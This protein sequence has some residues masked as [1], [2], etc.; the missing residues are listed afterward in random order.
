ML[1]ALLAVL[2][3]GVPVLDAARRRGAF[4]RPEFYLL[5]ALYVYASFG[6]LTNLYFPFGMLNFIL[7]VSEESIHKGYLYSALAIFA[8]Y[9]GGG[10]FRT[11]QIRAAPPRDD[12]LVALALLC[13]VGA[14][15]LNL[16]YFYTFDLLTGGFDRTAFI[17]QFK[18]GAGFSVPYLV[19]LLSSLSVLAMYERRPFGWL[20]WSVFG[21]FA[22]LH[23]PVGDRREVLALFVVVIAAKL[24]RGVNF[25]RRSFVVSASAVALAGVATGIWR[26]VGLSG[27]V[28]PDPVRVFD[29]LSEFARPFVTLL[30]YVEHGYA[31]L[32]GRGFAEAVLNI[33]PASIS[34]FP[35]FISSGQEFR[36]IVESLGVFEGRVP[37]YGFF[38][39]TEALLNFGPSGIPLFFFIAALLLRLLSD[40]SARNTDFAFLIPV[41]CSAMAASFVRNPLSDVLVTYFWTIAFGVALFAGS[42]VLG[43]LI[44]RPELR[45]PRMERGS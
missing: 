3:V 11:R 20:S 1:L 40:F 17:D 16:Y 18:G 14:L 30:Y 24:L 10:L 38:P 36:A 2:A 44:H 13:C 9:L 42:A 15:A 23:L 34:P 37:G 29:S 5:L 45:V 22:A 32:Y 43:R 27:I 28:A 7:P 19:V 6:Y 39:V 4:A 8:V 12:A 41:L 21:L 33:L 25:G 35:K 31:P 26:T